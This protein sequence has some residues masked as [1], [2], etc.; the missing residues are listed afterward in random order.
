MGKQ[1]KQKKRERDEGSGLKGSWSKAKRASLK[2]ASHV[3]KKAE[4]THKWTEEKKRG[5]RRK[6]MKMGRRERRWRRIEPYYINYGELTIVKN[7]TDKIIPKI[8]KMMIQ[9]QSRDIISFLNSKYI[10]QCDGSITL[11]VPGYNCKK[12]YDLRHSIRSLTKLV[13]CV[14]SNRKE[15]QNRNKKII[16]LRIVLRMFEWIQERRE[17]LGLIH[18]RP[19]VSFSP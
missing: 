5:I 19:N 14:F 7:K 17:W 1:A 3:R 15:N 6:M 11:W 12:I 9:L 16:I 10:P 18:T 2:F 13:L 8:K 4:M